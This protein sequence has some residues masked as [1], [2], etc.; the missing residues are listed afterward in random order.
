MKVS[1]IITNVST[2]RNE[3]LLIAEILEKTD[4]K[5]MGQI[6]SKEIEIATSEFC[7][8]CNLRFEIDSQKFK[9]MVLSKKPVAK[10]PVAK[11]PVAKKP[12]AKKK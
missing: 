10:K 11:K 3:D 2:S 4:A 7:Y 1:K 9:V 6:E 12:V 8:K 5:K